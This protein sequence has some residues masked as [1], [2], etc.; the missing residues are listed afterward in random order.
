MLNIKPANRQWLEETNAALR[1]DGVEASDRVRK[2]ELQWRR[3]NVEA[4]IAAGEVDV[5][6]RNAFMDFQINEIRSFFLTQTNKDRGYIQPPFVGIYYSCGEFWEASVPLIM[7]RVAV[8]A[9]KQLMMPDDLKIVI[10][11]NPETLVEYL[12]FYAD[13]LDYAYMIDNVR[14]GSDFALKLFLSGDYH[15]RGSGSLLYQKMA[16]SKAF[17]DARMAVE[18]FL[19]AF[20]AAKVNL[21]D[22]D[23]REQIG[24]KLDIAVDRCINLGVKDLSQIRD[25][26]VAFPDVSSRYSLEERTF[27]ELWGAYRVAHMVGTSVLRSLT[28]RDCRPSFFPNRKAG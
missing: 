6:A 18:I 8:N 24:H 17:E 19:K 26:V 23:L 14:G 5:H 13:C 28:G 9:F 22:K 4:M 20:I 3:E 27:G 12:S 16:N 7:G 1:S 2:A 11:Q 25:Y 15:L 21:S 10:Q